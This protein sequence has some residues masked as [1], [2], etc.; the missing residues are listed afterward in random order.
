M[1]KIRA[2]IIGTGVISTLHALEYLTSPHAE[3]VAVCDIDPDAAARKGQAWGVPAD[4]VYGDY[5]DLLG[6]RDVDLVEILLPHHLHHQVTLDAIA[7]GKHV[8]L[9]KPMA[10]SVAQADEMIAA[11][12][13]AGVHLKVYENAVFYPPLLRAKELVEDGA[14]GEPITIRH[15]T[16]AGRSED[17]WKIPESSWQWR[18]DRDLAGG[19]AWLTDDGHHAYAVSWLF[20]EM[21]T[22]VHA[23]A[24]KTE[25]GNGWVVD[26]PALVSWE[27]PGNRFGSWEAVKAPDLELATDHYAADDM[28]EITGTRGIVW[29]LRGMGRMLD[30][31]P[32]VLYRDRRLRAFSDIAS[33]WEQSFILSTRHFVDALR[34][35]G[36]PFL[37]AQ[38]GRDIL[39]W[40]VAAEQSAAR[41][42]RVRL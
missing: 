32:V 42:E 23:W 19:G 11:A 29:V 27:F 15:K 18:R 25:L 33:G 9:Q 6:S 10:T 30:V 34:D 28:I 12:N 2:A 39:R 41:G 31:P 38:Q 36:Q 40:C 22:S 14:I 16:T 37:S 21:P 17:A 1:S 24:G 13:D 7:A 26:A 20:F 35:G 3:I 8:S 5:R 4:R